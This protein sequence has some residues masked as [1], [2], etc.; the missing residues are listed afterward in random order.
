MKTLASVLV[1]IAVSC[2]AAWAAAGEPAPCQKIRVLVTVG[3]HGYEEAPFDAMWNALPGVTWK[4]IEVPKQADMLKPGLEKQYDVIAM[5]DMCPGISP[6]QQQAFVELLKNGIGV[7]SMHHNM[8]AHQRWDEFRKIIGAKFP[9]TDSTI[10]GAKFKPSTWDHDQEM[11]ISVV[12]KDHPITKG[13]CDFVIHDETYGGYWVSPC[14]QVLLKTDNPKNK[15]GQIAW[16][17]NYG[18]SRVAYLML[19]HDHQAWQNPNYAKLLVQAIH[20]AACR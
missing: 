15:P 12:C 18:K 6:K 4:K 20:W 1:A 16:T 17:A 14:V 11:K 10:D 8:G 2:A 5:Y 13:V 9:T 3:G 7:V 19:G